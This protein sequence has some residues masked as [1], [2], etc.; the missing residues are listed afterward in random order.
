MK[1]CFH[2]V[3]K[4]QAPFVILKTR[5]KFVWILFL[6]IM[7]TKFYRVTVFWI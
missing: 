7:P 4:Y 6:V 2:K 3:Q 1:E 5:E